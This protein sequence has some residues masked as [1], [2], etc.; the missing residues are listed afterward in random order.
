M[1]LPVRVV[2]QPG[3]TVPCYMTKGAAGADI[4]AFV[5]KSITIQPNGRATVPTG[6]SLAIP[7]GYE[8]QIRPRSGLAMRRGVFLVNGPGTIDSDYRGELMIV[9][10]NLGSEPFTVHKGDRIAQMVIAPVTRAAFQKVPSLDE[11]ERGGGGF[12]STGV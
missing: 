9:L 2:A 1:A 6:L 12:G 7:E 8:A 4:C 10:G 3:A 5:H 11:T